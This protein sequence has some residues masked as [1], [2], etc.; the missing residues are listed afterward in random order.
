M[1]DCFLTEVLGFNGF[2]QFKDNESSATLVM[3]ALSGDE[4]ENNFLNLNGDK[5]NS[6]SWESFIFLKGNSIVM[7]DKPVS[8]NLLSTVAY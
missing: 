6:C 4:E 8:C 3:Q 1:S 5:C 2:Q 7:S